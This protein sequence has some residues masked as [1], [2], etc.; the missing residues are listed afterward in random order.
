MPTWD[1]AQVRKAKGGYQGL[2]QQTGFITVI[3]T[4]K[5][6]VPGR[7]HYPGKSPGARLDVLC[8][9]N[10][11]ELGGRRS[12]KAPQTTVNSKR[13]CFRSSGEPQKVTE[14]Q[15]GVRVLPRVAQLAGEPL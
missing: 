5:Q 3:G 1:A 14:G 12:L 2:A 11:T 4:R 8:L 6:S 10:T 13:F 9:E 7:E 15:Y